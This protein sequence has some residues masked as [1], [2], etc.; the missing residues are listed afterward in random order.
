MNS[1]FEQLKKTADIALADLLERGADSSLV[2]VGRSVKNEFNI[3]GGEFSLMRTTDSEAIGL[4]VIKGNKKGDISINSFDREVLRNAAGEVIKV[5]EGSSADEAWVF[6]KNPGGEKHFSIGVLDADIEKLFDRVNE[7]KETLDR[8]YPKIKIDQLISSHVM[9]YGVLAGSDGL[10]YTT[11]YGYYNCGLSFIGQD[12]DEV[13]SFFGADIIT[14]DLDTPFI[15][16]GDVKRNIEAC[17][18]SIHTEALDGTFTGCM[19][20]TPDCFGGFLFDIIGNFAGDSGVLEQTSIWLNK[21]GSKVADERITVS[22]NPISDYAKF[23]SPFDGSGYI[24]EN[25]DLIKDGVFES[26]AISDYVARKRGM[27]K[28]KNTGANVSVKP[29]SESLDGIISGIDKGI[30]VGRFSGGSPS[31]NGDFSGVAKNSFLIENGRVTKPLREVM[32]NG[33]L[34]D[35]LNNLRGLS[36]ELTENGISSLPYA[37]FDNVVISGK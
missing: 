18:R 13:S 1:K 9:S 21:L 32:I 8:D 10:I 20:L 17:E 19:L 2:S 35:I 34:A 24:A 14:T 25:F 4:K 23:Y 22:L 11:E 12:G 5:A 30:L 29:G 27:T 16:Q 36:K 3:D 33:N 6:A 31:S 28:A 37:A 7:L 26:F 15:E